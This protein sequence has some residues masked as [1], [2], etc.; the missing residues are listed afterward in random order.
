MCEFPVRIHM[1]GVEPIRSDLAARVR[2]ALEVVDS[3]ERVPGSKEILSRRKAIAFLIVRGATLAAAI[4]GVQ[5][6]RRQFSP[7]QST[8]EQTFDVVVGRTVRTLVFVA[9]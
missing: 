7:S 3:V 4:F 2:S 6:R 8:H 1:E 5:S 9:P